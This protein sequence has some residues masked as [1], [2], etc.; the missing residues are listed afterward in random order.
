MAPCC[1]NR[2]EASSEMFS[3]SVVVLVLQIR[4][5]ICG[6]FVESHSITTP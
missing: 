5:E 2:E 6:G 1:K 3:S 4:L